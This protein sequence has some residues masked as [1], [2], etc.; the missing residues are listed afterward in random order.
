MATQSDDTKKVSLTQMLS[1]LEEP[2]ATSVGKR[3]KNLT[4]KRALKVIPDDK[5]AKI[6]RT[7]AYDETVEGLNR[8]ER[9]ID[10]NS[11]STLSFPLD[12]E[13]NQ[14]PSAADA[15]VNLK[16]KNDL[17]KL[18]LGM[19][20]E[21][22]GQSMDTKY[23]KAISAE[24]AKERHLDLQKTRIRLNEYAAKMRRQ[25]KI[26]SKGYHRILKQERMRKQ[27]KRAETDKEALLGEFERLQKLRAE[28]RAT[29]RHK[30]SGKWA[31][32]SKF[33]TRY[34]D[35][36]VALGNERLEKPIVPESYSHSD[37]E[38]DDSSTEA[39]SH[40]LQESKAADVAI[41][42]P[43]PDINVDE[44]DEEHQQ[45]QRKLMRE[46]FENDDVVAEFEEN[47]DKI[48]DEEQPKDIDTYLPGW[49]DW[50]GPGIRVNEKK[51]KAF[52]K[53]ATRVKRKDETL[54]NVIISEK[55]NDSIKALQP[56]QLPYGVKNDKHHA[57]LLS[58]PVTST[59][60]DQ[61]NLREAIQPKV[62][63]RMGARIE[64]INK[65]VVLG[66]GSKAAWV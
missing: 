66:G 47:K 53:K 6:N 1:A 24:E 37:S 22:T 8:W 55:A 65:S 64:P 26:K 2:V 58:R 41:D 63:T 60:S 46:A 36:A 51:R 29:L 43:L 61:P 5:V 42:T 17:E 28:E 32:N 45:E 57:K 21:S 7:K 3:L 4:R 33:R 13:P 9:V 49:N 10:Y 25:K 35:E 23:Q 27:L 38:S 11:H 20:V 19:N 54:A 56:K 34:Y 14:L 12:T 52:V 48:A 39:S 18:V 50:A 59:F 15:L 16:P 44:P 62:V 30:N 31:K 40:D